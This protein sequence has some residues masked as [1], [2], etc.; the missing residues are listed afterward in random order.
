MLG[1][2]LAAIGWKVDVAEAYQT[3]PATPDGS[4]IAAVAAADL[5][6]FASSSAVTGFTA[7]VPRASWPRVAAA[8]G[9]IT[10][11]TA[12]TAGFAE[13]IEAEQHDLDGLVGAVLQW[14]GAKL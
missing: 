8:I 14:A 13:V 9:P 3:I 5:V 10:A 11:E 2:G 1:E 12:R 7:S 4:S 6:A